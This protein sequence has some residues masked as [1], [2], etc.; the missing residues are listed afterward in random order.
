M[1]S[2][3]RV[4]LASPLPP[5]YT[6]VEVLTSHLR[7]V[8]LGE[9]FVVE[10]P[11]PSRG[12]PAREKGEFS[13]R[14]I[15]K[16]LDDLARLWRSLGAPGPR[17]VLTNLVQNSAGLLR[18]GAFVHAARLRHA[19]VAV[20]SHGD[21][22]SSFWEG[23]PRWLR[24]WVRG[25]FR[26]MDRILL[27]APALARQYGELAE[28]RRFVHVAPGIPS[29][30]GSAARSGK[31]RLR[32]CFIGYLT[33]AKGA[34]DLIR[35]AFEILKERDVEF[36]FI[37]DH[38]PV[39]RNVR[40][41]AGGDNRAELLRL[42]GDKPDP[43]LVFHGPQPEAEKWRILGSSDI[44]ALPSY[45]EALPVAVLEALACGLPQVLTPVGGIPQTVEEGVQALFVPAGDL[46]QLRA[47]LMRLIDDAGLRRRMGQAARRRYEDRHTP[48]RYGRRL[49]EVFEGMIDGPC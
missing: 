17:V 2:T 20:I 46:A 7:N 33:R 8:P 29:P 19:P 5:P 38:I 10:T 11:F 1:R 36:H 14:N 26:R 34:H 43:R 41:A 15:L 44:F 49:R 32:I 23:A 31:D 37:G 21:G 30:A 40:L 13:L 12:R 24:W 25:V 3:C 22:F 27:H 39:E 48:E 18:Y 16:T 47:A 9:G 42:V 6:G 45:S 28:A 35:A 4:I